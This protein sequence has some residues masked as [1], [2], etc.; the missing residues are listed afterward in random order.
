MLIPSAALNGYHIN[1]ALCSKVMERK[2]N[3]LPAEEARAG[4][5]TVLCAYFQSLAT[6]EMFKYLDHIIT[7]TENN[8]LSVLVKLWKVRKEWSRLTRILRREGTNEPTLGNFL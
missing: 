6:M 5:Y 8:W 2:F 4:T 7:A 1:M 3:R